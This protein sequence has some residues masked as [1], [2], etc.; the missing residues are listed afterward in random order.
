MLFLLAAVFLCILSLGIS[1]SAFDITD[2]RP[3]Q[4]ATKIVYGYS[5]AGRELV[6]YQF[7]NGNN[8]M[9]CGFG[10][11]GYEDNFDKDGGCLVYTGDQ[12]M[13]LLDKNRDLITDYGWT[14][15]V[16]PS[17]NPD[18]LMDGYSCNGPGRCTTTYLN[19][20]GQLVRGKGVDLNRSFPHAWSRYTSNRNFN[21]SQPLAAKEAQALAQFVRNVKGKGTNVCIDAHGWYSQIITSNGKDSVLFKT[22]AS[23]FPRNT[24]ANCTNA[25]GYFTAYTASIGYTSCLFEFPDGLYSMDAFLRSGYCSSFNACILDL[26]KAYGTYNA[27]SLDC[28][29]IRFDDVIPWAWYHE[30]I[31]YVLRNAIFNGISNTQFAPNQTMSRAMLVTTLWRMSADLPEPLPNEKLEDSSAAEPVPSEPPDGQNPDSGSTEPGDPVR[32]PDVESGAWY[33]EAVVWAAKNGIVNG[34]PDGTFAPTQTITR[35]Q[36]ATILYRYAKWRGRHAA[37]TGTL[38]AFPDAASVPEYAVEAMRWAVG[39]ELIQGV[40]GY[41]SKPILQPK[42]GASRAQAATVLTR[43]REGIQKSELIKCPIRNNAEPNTDDGPVPESGN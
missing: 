25:A 28:P 37:T 1:A 14:I 5:G 10:L 33:E 42:G 9:I 8:V 21:G 11:H 24:Y 27:H 17:M 31:D 26:L 4:S 43:F 18:G 13:Q 39:I 16:L 19:E 36:L 40:T 20:N 32:F 35:E 12:L 22:F 23:R 3:P 29:S 38:D 7:G 2:V 15:Y 30:Y 6:A 41:G 34:M